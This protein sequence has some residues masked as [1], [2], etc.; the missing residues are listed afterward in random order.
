VEKSDHISAPGYSHWQPE[1]RHGTPSAWARPAHI[2]PFKPPVRKAGPLA[3]EATSCEPGAGVT[4][5]ERETQILFLIA[6]GYNSNEM[7]AHL[8]RTKATVESFVRR[9]VTK[10]SARSRAHVVARAFQ[11]GHLW[12]DDERKL[13]VRRTRVHT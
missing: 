12:L 3:H 11:A 13:C 7:A 10:F 5:T 2:V 1:A 4:L 8:N 6:Q 9:L